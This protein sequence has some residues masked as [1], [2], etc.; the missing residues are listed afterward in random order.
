MS[1]EPRGGTSIQAK[2]VTTTSNTKANKK[3]QGA[4]NTCAR[5]IATKRIVKANPPLPVAALHA[6]NPL[7]ADVR[8]FFFLIFLPIRRLKKA[9]L[10]EESPFSFKAIPGV[11]I[12]DSPIVAETLSQQSIGQQVVPKN[13]KKAEETMK[14][15][16]EEKIIKSEN[17]KIGYI[18]LWALGVPVPVLLLVYFL[19][20]C[21]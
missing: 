1:S 13:F 20:G 14:K 15:Y 16:I 12:R 3:M 21:N 11:R 6:T 10:L 4:L 5:T 18:L 17:G 8:I 7:T 19:R 9:A 2:I